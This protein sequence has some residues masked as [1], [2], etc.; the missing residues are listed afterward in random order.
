M[1]RNKFSCHY[2]TCGDFDGEFWPS[3]E[4]FGVICSKMLPFSAPLARPRHFLA[5]K[6]IEYR[7]TLDGRR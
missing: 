4:E 1:A 6:N 5:G 7:L 2:T 3:V